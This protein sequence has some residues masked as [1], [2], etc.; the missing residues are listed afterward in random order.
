MRN[1]FLFLVGPVLLSF[2][3]CEDLSTHPNGPYDLM[4]FERG[5]GGNL[6][7]IVSPSISIDALEIVVTRLEFRDT[8][9]QMVVFKNATNA[10]TF[11]A[12][13]NGL[14]GLCQITGDFTPSRLPTGTW[15]RVY[16][17]ED[18]RKEEVTNIELRNSLLNFE[19][20]VRDKL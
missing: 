10:T 3:S 4:Q 19:Q 6:E 18:S 5:G 12:L 1:V 7:F 8:T 17:V 9:I 20:I 16:M 11:E 13:E 14:S 15:V 2:G